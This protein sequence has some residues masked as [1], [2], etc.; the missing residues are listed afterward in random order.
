MI[1]KA[2]KGK[3][4]RGALEYDLGKEHGH[5]IG[6]N[7]AGES[8]RELAGEFGAIRQLRPNLGKAVLHVSL[9][10][11]VGETLSDDQWKAI[12]EC[13]IDGM[14]LAK[15]QYIITRH[16]DTE[17]EHIHILANRIRFDGSVTSDSLD[18][19]R[20]EVLMRQIERDY[21]LQAVAPS[22]EAE[23]RAPTKGEI[24]AHIRTGV[25]STR[26]QLQRLCDG[27]AQDCTSFTQYQAQL[28]AVGVDMVPL[29]QL[30]GAKL[31]GLT[32]RLDGVMMKGSDLGKRYS[33]AGLATR[34]ITYEQDRDAAAISRC[35]EREA[36]RA[37]VEPDRVGTPGQISERPGAGRDAGTAGA[38]D[39]SADGRDTAELNRD[40]TQERAGGSRVS[41]ENHQH[42]AGMDRSGAGSAESS[43]QPEPSRGAH[44]VEPLHPDNRSGTGY[45]TAGE[46]VLALAG[47]AEDPKPAGR[48]SGSATPGAGRDRSLEALQRQIKAL[49]VPLF[50]IAICSARGGRTIAR[51][52]WDGAELEQSTTWLK[53][54]NARGNDIY[55]K[56]AGEH[57]LV[58]VDGLKTDVLIVMER[59]GFR[60]AAIIET[61]PGSCQAWI[62]LSDRQLSQEVCDIA[63]YGLAQQF[64]GVI[65]EHR[66]SKDHHSPGNG[67]GRLAGFTNQAPQ[68]SRDGQP[69]YVLARDCCG[70]L[71]PGAPAYLRQVEYAID[72]AAAQKEKEKRLAAI[73]AVKVQNK[74]NYDPVLAYQ[75]QAQHLIVQGSAGN[76]QL[77]RLDQMIA[78]EMAKSG[79]WTQQE[80]EKGIRLASPAVESVKAGHI[81]AYAKAI[82]EIAWQAP[83]VQRHRQEQ[84][85]K[86]TQE[87][88]LQAQQNRPGQSR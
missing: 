3:G 67:F 24:E 53:R 4:F 45:S 68:H 57:G 55:I 33:P 49:G 80:I 34:G 48:G 9:S 85:H 6:T 63:A 61:R 79:N 54:M 59:Q 82:A 73:K 65:P 84:A 88:A 50:E 87:R 38:G 43:R 2:V 37:I 29:L 5:I 31:S 35:R 1:A 15:N 39:G 62:K 12:G 32:Y 28:E 47:A 44:D 26:Q 21:G 42:D 51:R 71:A 20:Q 22:I 76:D 52:Q 40:R 81:E 18:Y 27:A 70:M 14:D 41:P 17:H 36:A 19:K 60:P 58:L 77:V 72:K 46:R 69:P 10:A 86:E 16:S 74:Q 7:M 83:E 56:P 8:V 75:Q 64:G 66:A 11:A 30:E 78:T 23:R 25:P 13:Y